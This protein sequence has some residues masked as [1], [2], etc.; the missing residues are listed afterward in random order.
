MKTMRLKLLS[1]KISS[2]NRIMWPSDA[3]TYF[4]VILD[5]YILTPDEPEEQKDEKEDFKEDDDEDEGII[6][7]DSDDEEDNIPLK[8]EDVTLWYSTFLKTLERQYPLAF[9]EVVKVVMSR[10]PGRKRNGLKNVLGKST[11][12]TL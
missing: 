1:G 6:S 4:R 2:V 12:H 5:S 8:A 7:L 11:K 3:I 9:D 10:T